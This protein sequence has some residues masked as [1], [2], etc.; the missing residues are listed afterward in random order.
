M[1]SAYDGWDQDLSD[2]DDEQLDEYR[3]TKSSVLFCVESTA[4]MLEPTL[5]F[6]PI[7]SAT[8][9][10][11]TA[12][13]PTATDDGSAKGKAKGKGKLSEED[14]AK[15]EIKKLRLK[16]KDRPASKMEIVL[17]AAYAM[18][19]RKVISSPKDQVGIVIWNTA[20]TDN[21]EHAKLANSVTLFPPEQVTANN[22]RK[23]KEILE[24]CESDP[25]FL[26]KK[27]K[28]SNGEGRITDTFGHCSTLLMQNSPRAQNQIFWVTDNDDPVRGVTQLF[29]VAMN[30]RRDL[31]DRNIDLHPFLVPPSPQKGFDLD[32]FYGE[33]VSIHSGDDESMA[34]D[35][36]D[37]HSSLEIALFGMI[38]NMRLKE[39]AKRVAF[40]IPFHLAED[41]TIGVSGYNMV[42]EE[43]KKLPT[44][45]D[46]NT[47]RGLQVVSEVVYKDGELGTELERDQIKKYFQVGT[48][49]F[50]KG[51]RAAKI[52]FSEDEVRKVKALGRPPGLRLLGFLPREGNLHFWQSVKQS[53][54]VYPEEERFEGSTR[55]FA[56][57][58]KSMV[59]KDLI[60][61]CSFIG[62]RAA[63]PQIV[64]LLPQE[65]ELNEAGVQ[66]L[67]PGF[68][69]CQLPFADD[70]RELGIGETLSCLQR[71]EDGDFADE[72]PAIDIAKQIIKH[73]TKSYKP[74]LFPNPALNYFYACLAATAL[75][76]D[77]IPEPEDKT[78]PPYESIDQ[79]A[80][81]FI[82]QLRSLIPPEEFD[83]S[84]IQ[85]SKS[86]RPKKLEELGPPPDLT[87]FLD[88]LSNEK[89]GD[90]TKFKNP[91]LKSVLKQIG[92]KTSGNKSELVETLDAYL[93]EHNL[94][95]D[96]SPKKKKRK[97][98]EKEEEDP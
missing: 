87:E 55:T 66:V 10:A 26:A 90:L 65:E 58:L 38:Q 69:L 37:V 24:S 12:T 62:R 25:D 96:E 73:T 7:P 94:I 92:Q 80:G 83:A 70:I 64:V 28:P 21:T 91:E 36:P 74:D 45:V 46:L 56:A 77:D 47:E 30:R 20:A 52:F 35:W 22:L 63:R 68:H 5:D 54:F 61:I 51:T 76:E 23:M 89:G 53:Y 16:D 2:D 57:L 4:S 29:N 82:A 42:G 72:Q 43:K 71:D 3:Y 50:T 44:K 33:I 14:I 15:Q 17:L 88:Q 75:G 40:K 11:P 84:R 13:A 41:F 1:N 79:R 93:R 60:A 97:Q 48:S 85:T 81:H 49:D 98:L 86:V 19:K 32:K 31:K 67:P 95:T 34:F 59:K 39:S 6:D 18:M 78:F 8:F 27:F 9:T